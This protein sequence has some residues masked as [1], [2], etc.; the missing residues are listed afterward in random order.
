MDPKPEPTK[1][2]LTKTELN[3][4]GLPILGGPVFGRGGTM[5]GHVVGYKDCTLEG[6][7]GRLLGVRWPD[8]KL[9]WPCSKGC[10]V[11][12]EGTWKIG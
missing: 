4:S 5:S 6:C 7:R 10:E 9:T 11:T 1:T 8:G 12:R 3:E 2:G